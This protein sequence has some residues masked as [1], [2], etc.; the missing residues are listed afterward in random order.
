MS[1]TDKAMVDVPASASVDVVDTSSMR[2][3]LIAGMKDVMQG[4]ITTWQAKAACN[5]AQQIYNVTALEV[6]VML[7]QEKLRGKPIQSVSFGPMGAGATSTAQSAP[8]NGMDVAE[9]QPAG[10][11]HGA[12][13][14]NDSPP[15]GTHARTHARKSSRK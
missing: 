7:A 4:R 1:L 8:Y 14:K 11:V 13:G 6:K 2:H 12:S 10:L 9:P 15:A 5:F 3:F